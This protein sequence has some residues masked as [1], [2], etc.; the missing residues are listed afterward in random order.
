MSAEKSVRS[1]QDFESK[2]I[3]ETLSVRRRRTTSRRN[4]VS[5]TVYLYDIEMASSPC[6][7]RRTIK[8][9]ASKIGTFDGE[10]NEAPITDHQAR[11]FSHKVKSLAEKIPKHALFR[12]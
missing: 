1:Q 10:T 8:P 12:R 4:L 3:T 2:I 5:I 7:R 11:P 9:H 6:S